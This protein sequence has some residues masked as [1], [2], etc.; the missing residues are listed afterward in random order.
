MFKFG[1][2]SRNNLSEAHLDL[3][4]VFNEVIKIY[5]CSVIEGMRSRDEQDKL[6]AAG[7]SKLLWP[8]SKHN[9]APSQAVDVIPYPIDWNDA[10][11]FTYLA[12]IVKGVASQLGIVI[13]WGGD[14]DSDNN[15]KDQ[16]F[17]DLP[18]FELVL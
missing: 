12:G 7:K 1:T 4:K 11:R 3:Q 17:N 15:F 6:Y 9:L 8:Q 14:W 10:R 5:D 16:T 2:R 18:H 13:R